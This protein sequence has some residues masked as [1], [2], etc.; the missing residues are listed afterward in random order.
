[1]IVVKSLTL[2]ANLQTAAHELV[3]RHTSRG[4]DTQEDIAQAVGLERG[5]LSQLLNKPGEY[6]PL[7]TAVQLT[8][9]LKDDYLL[10]A[11]CAASGGV[12]L[13][14]CDEAL[15]A[16]Q[17]TEAF[18]NAM[19]LLGDGMRESGEALAVATEVIRD[20]VAT[21]AEKARVRRE[22]LETISALGKLLHSI[23][24]MPERGASPADRF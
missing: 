3:A 18:A 24:R 23:D 19:A 7:H 10:Q 14:T 22:I 5:R 9:T 15:P 16:A 8:R 17:A 13:P 20:R 11:V 12:Y 2:Q 4:G 21:A 6:L 1:M